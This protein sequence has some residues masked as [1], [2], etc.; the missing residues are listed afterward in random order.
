MNPGLALIGQIGGYSIGDLVKWAIIVCAVVAI[1]W[2]AF[3]AMGVQPPAWAIQIFWVVVIAF[4][5]LI[6]IRIV[7]SM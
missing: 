7:M 3:K 2:I 4:V 1:A 5:A 6:G